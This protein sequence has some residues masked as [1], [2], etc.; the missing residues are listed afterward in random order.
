MVLC[1]E[2]AFQF[3]V[4][5]EDADGIHMVIDGMKRLCSFIN[6]GKLQAQR[7]LR[8]FKMSKQGVKKNTHQANRTIEVSLTLRCRTIQNSIEKSHQ[9]NHLYTHPEKCLMTSI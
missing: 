8:F 5:K 4:Q 2:V 6:I 1:N 9:V 3:G 7:T